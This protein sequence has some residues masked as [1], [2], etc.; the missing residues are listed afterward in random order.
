MIS[1][2]LLVGIGGFIG[3]VLRYIL[4]GML[5]HKSFF[6]IGTLFVNFIGSFFLALTT[7]SIDSD[8]VL[9]FINIGLLGSFTT[10]S[11]FSYESFKLLENGQ[12]RYFW[13]NVI[14]NLLL[15]IGGVFL[16]Y[17]IANLL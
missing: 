14:T 1:P 7:F 15:C 16:G 3:A 2:I 8:F 11:T 9:H 12:V 4:T 6:P 13:I 5:I 17:M 10:Y